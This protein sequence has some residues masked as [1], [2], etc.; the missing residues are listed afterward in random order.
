MSR[1]YADVARSA[2]APTRRTN[3]VVQTRANT[4]LFEYL[5]I[6]YP[7]PVDTMLAQYIIDN[8]DRLHNCRDFAQV[9]AEQIESTEGDTI[10]V[11]TS[12]IWAV[13]QEFLG[14]LHDEDLSYAQTRSGVWSFVPS[15][16]N[17]SNVED[18]LTFRDV[19]DVIAQKF[20]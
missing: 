10:S 4:P 5:T 7:I 3:T 8:K 9:V 6:F 1:S 19:L 13:C 14:R 17:D 16:D 18:V 15:N 2:L 20:P 12:S 11:T